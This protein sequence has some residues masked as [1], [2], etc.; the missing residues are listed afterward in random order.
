MDPAPAG[1]PRLVAVVP[2]RDEAAR[3][4]GLLARLLGGAAAASSAPATAGP[5]GDPD[6]DR[7][8]LAIVA[9][10]GSSD[11]TQDLARA[12]G[13]EVV[14]APPGRGPQLRAGGIRALERVGPDDLLLFVH[15]DNRPAPGALAA[16]R[17]AAAA[18][19]EALAFA[20]SQRVDAP[21]WVYRRIERAADR[22]AARGLVL[23]DSGLCVRAGAYEAVGGY[24]PLP[25]FED[26][27]LSMRLAARGPVRLVPGARMVV[28]ARRWKREGALR[29]TVRNRILTLGW[30]L[31]VP[32][33]RLA[34]WYP[35]HRDDRPGSAAGPGSASPP[36]I[37]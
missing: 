12:A 26:L 32:A 36:T 10:G 9:D 5:S 15:A 21:G 33:E 4:P 3:L 35:R 1:A 24:A 23:G 2:A 7:A 14:D 18:L 22:R 8:A 17:A 31:G 19:P 37:P 27:D 13:A 30:R 25:L 11:G 34:A 29:A 28:C 6:P 20:P 16:L